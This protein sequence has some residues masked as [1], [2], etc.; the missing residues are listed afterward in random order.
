VHRALRNLAG[1]PDSFKAAFPLAGE[2]L[3]IFEG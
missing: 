2:D 1:V 3:P